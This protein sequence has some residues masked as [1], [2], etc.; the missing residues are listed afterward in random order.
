MSHISFCDGRILGLIRNGAFS[1]GGSR[2]LSNLH[3]KLQ[4]NSNGVTVLLLMGGTRSLCEV[5]SEARPL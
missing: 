3:F 1:T 2:V 5:I 4:P